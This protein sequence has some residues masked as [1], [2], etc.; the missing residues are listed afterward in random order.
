MSSEV[1][2]K[3]S[4]DVTEDVVNPWEVKASDNTGIDYEKLIR[5]CVQLSIC[6]SLDRRSFF[7]SADRFG[8]TRIS[9]EL[10]Q[11]IESVTGKPV[12]HF[13]RRGIFFSHR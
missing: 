10:I 2:E 13:I 4:A 8:S 1:D 6:V 9:P 11:R 12:H 3:T 7:C 5:K